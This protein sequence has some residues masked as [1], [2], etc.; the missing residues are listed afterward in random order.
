MKKKVLCGIVLVLSLTL[1]AAAWDVL[2]HALIMEQI[3]GGAAQA[4]GN[5][6]YGITSPDFVNYLYGSP[7]Y[8]WLYDQTHTNFMRLWRMAGNGPKAAAE[9]SLALGFAA[10]NGLWGADYAAHV[11][12]LTIGDPA[13]GY[14]IAKAALLEQIFMGMGIWGS[15]PID[16]T[17]L[18]FLDRP[19][20]LPFRLELCHNLIEYAIDVV[21][22]QTNPGLAQRVV[23]AAAGRDASIQRLIKTAYAGP[24]VAFSQQTESPL[25]HAA[26][27]TMLQ[28]YETAFQQRVVMYATLY[29]SA[30]SLNGLLGN[31]DGYLASLASTIFGLT[32]QPGQAAQLLGAV[33][34]TGLVDDVGA[35][36]GATVGYVRDQLKAHKVVYG[37]PG[38]MAAEENADRLGPRR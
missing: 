2:A 10:H 26:A 17:G 28:T 34:M 7:Y 32:L 13:H 19:E 33:L 11:S 29:A 24:L 31:L 35:E 36:L 27:L 14:V 23:A 16:D 25:T 22:W 12:S 6:I 1:T 37:A 20:L 4:N 18:V 9:R 38:L 3:K 8:D 5:E 21:V 15:I 30:T